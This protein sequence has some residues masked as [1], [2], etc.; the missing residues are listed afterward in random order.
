M[1][2]DKD[3]DET[4]TQPEDDETGYDASDLIDYYQN[5]R[6]RG[7]RIIWIALIIFIMGVVLLTLLET[8]AQTDAVSTPDATPSAMMGVHLLLDDGRQQWPIDL[9][10]THMAYAAQAL[11]AGGFVVQLIRDDDFDIAKWQAFMDWCADYDLTPV[12]RMATTYDRD[13]AY[14]RVPQA[15]SD[16]GY[17]AWANRFAE[18]L[19]ALQWPTDTQYVIVLNEVNQGDEWGGKPDAAAYARLQMDVSAA[20]RQHLPNPRILN[21]ALSLYAPHTGSLPFPNSQHHFVDANTFLDAIIAAQPDFFE[22]VD[23][24][25]SHVYPADFTAPPWQQTYGF[26]FMHDAVDTTQPP[27]NGIYNR[28]INGYEWELWKLDRFGVQKP[29]F[30]SE[31]GWRHAGDGTGNA[32]L[33]YPEPTLAAQYLDLALRGNV[34]GYADVPATGWQPLLTDPRLIGVVVF[35]FNGAPHEWWHTNLLQVAPDGTISGSYALYD[36]LMR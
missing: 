15:D 28:G 35:A 1:T 20:L 34:A 16:G 12:I 17:T 31:L 13:N 26:D 21:A 23:I 2:S 10:H 8:R 3:F 25:N 30:I 14:W 36:V 9:W 6:R 18:F 4:T 24:W 5:T 33:N 27:P 29:V 19:G 32:I 22:A 11:P 7:I